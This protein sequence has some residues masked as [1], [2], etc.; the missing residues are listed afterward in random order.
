MARTSTEKTV[1]SRARILESLRAHNHQSFPLPQAPPQ[2]YLPVTA[3]G[4]VSLV[5]RFTQEV[6]RLTGK[7]YALENTPSIAEMV[8]TIL[9]TDR[10]VLA[11]ENLPVPEL[12]DALTQHGVSLVVPTVR[13]DNRLSAYQAL[14]SIR[15]G[16]TGVD[17]AFA[18]TG[19]LALVTEKGQGRIASLLPSVH[20]AL[21]RRD[22]LYPTMEAW[23]KHEG[24]AALTGSRSVAFVTGP[25][26]T[27]D[28]EMQTI[29]GVHGPREIHVLI[30]GANVG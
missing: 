23:L 15:V 16:I 29:L 5:Q 9:G 7:V 18:T 26:R 24:A 30:I 27:S 2:D 13:G 14:E 6:E 10:V 4:D 1:S 19:T 17:A 25:S 28:I 21:L 3:V 20:I 11:W 8:M 22:C 12:R